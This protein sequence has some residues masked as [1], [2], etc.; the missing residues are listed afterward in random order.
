ANPA[1]EKFNASNKITLTATDCQV[2]IFALPTTR[3]SDCDKVR[4]IL[5]SRSVNYDHVEAPAGS[6]PVLRV[7]DTEVSATAGMDAAAV[8]A[9][10]GKVTAALGAAGY[11]AKFDFTGFSWNGTRAGDWWMILIILFI[12]VIYVTMVYGPIAAFLVEL[13]PTRIRYTSM[14]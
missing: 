8:K 1:L 5:T 9:F 4:N 6:A 11:P 12:Q 3:Y 2:H 10:E 14:S 13:F 7:N